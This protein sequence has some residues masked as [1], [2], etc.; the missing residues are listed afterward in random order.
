MLQQLRGRDSSSTLIIPV[1]L[2]GN[3]QLR[4][5]RVGR[6]SPPHPCHLMTEK[7]CGQLSLALFS[8]LPHPLPLIQCKRHAGP[9][10]PSAAPDGKQGHL[11]S[12][13][14]PVASSPDCCSWQGVRGWTASSLIP[15][16]THGRGAV[17]P[18]LPCSHPRGWLTCTRTIKISSAMLS[19]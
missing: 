13:H 1:L 6:S 9:A 3:G 8:E 12:S 15:R 4:G 11:P 16:T 17:G 7:Q 14:D 2:T 19:R 10:L 18:V 5:R